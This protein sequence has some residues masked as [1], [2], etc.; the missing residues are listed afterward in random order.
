M[1]TPWRLRPVTAADE[2][3][4]RRVYAGTRQ[5]ELALTGWD[6][7]ECERFL[8]LQF[9]AQASHYV[10]HNPGAEHSVIESLLGTGWS[11]VGRLWLHQREQSVHVLDIALLPA[12]CGHG[13]GTQVLQQVL[14]Q[15][16]RCGRAVS[17]YVE[18]GNPARRLYERLGF[19]AEGPVQ[20]VH[21]G[22]AWRGVQQQARQVCDEQA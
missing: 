16:Q 7:A 4:L 14:Q 8:D 9:R 2:P 21:Q 13:L 22:M 12:H 1:H 17:I 6:A 3:L 19:M 10:A 18:Q 5:A 15:A 11:A 20:G